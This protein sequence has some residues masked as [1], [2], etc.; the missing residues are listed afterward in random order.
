MEFRIGIHLGDVMVDGERIYGD[1]INIAAR[2]EGLADPGGICMSA[3]I[4][5]QVRNKVDL[6]YEDIGQQNVKNIPEPIRV[7]RVLI[8]KSKTGSPKEEAVSLSDRPSIVV[9]PFDD[10][11]PGKDNEFFSDGLTEE[12]ITDLSCVR[13]LLVISSNSAMAYKGSK[14]RITEIAKEVN[15]RYVLEGSVRKA[16]NNLRI[17]AQLI[18]AATDAHLWAEK[19]SGTLD[20]VFDIQE[21]VSRSIVDSLKLKISPEENQR[22]TERPV[23]DL[24][25]YECYLR[26]KQ[27]WA[28]WTEDDIDAAIVLLERA[29]RIEGPNELLYAT[30]GEAYT[31]YCLPLP[32]KH[33]NTVL[34]KAESYAAKVFELNP[35]SPEG[36]ALKGAVL[37]HRGKT[38]E[39]LSYLKKLY[40]L[41]NKNPTALF[42]MTGI[43]GISGYMEQARFYYDKL[44]AVEPWSGINPGWIPYYRGDFEKAIDGYRKEY[45]MDPD[46][47]YTR[48]AY[49][50]VLAWA[51]RT[52]DACV[53]LEQIPRDTPDS[54]FCQFALFLI[55]AL[56]GRTD[57]ALRVITAE[58]VSIAKD[59]WQMA[60][61]MA[62]IYSLIN[63]TD[64]SLEWLENAVSR[65][66]I[67]YPFLNEHD[68]FLENIRGE[69]RFK[70]LMERI[71]YEWEH[72][73]V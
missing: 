2:L 44:T 55:N 5:E 53:I 10:I 15:V 3:T 1:G 16:G 30:L 26:A 34:E 14:K 19:F 38:Q 39:A 50:V 32:L 60:W 8:D 20:D 69:E 43:Y 17:T 64:E 48:W 25:A 40:T 35:D 73:E 67:N 66:F 23:R 31:R 42:W 58:L 29:L 51:R 68:P 56:R 4:H 24:V 52:N 7:Y 22:I 59:Q 70:K 33:V 62:S 28:R 63:R 36:H 37:V 21:K 11:S 65:G 46:S 6:E 54:I 41:N 71:K 47:P 13:D 61:M 45:E 18:D 9:L 12:I 49:G 27:K 72:F 57:E